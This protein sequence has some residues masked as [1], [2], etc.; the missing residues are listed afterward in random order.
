MAIYA[1]VV[2]LLISPVIILRKKPSTDGWV[3]SVLLLFPIFC[4]V[5]FWFLFSIFYRDSTLEDRALLLI[6]ALGI[7]VTYTAW[8]EMLWRSYHKQW[9]LSIKEGYAVG[10]IILLLACW[11]TFIFFLFLCGGIVKL[12][13]DQALLLI[14]ALVLFRRTGEFISNVISFLM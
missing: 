14:V 9:S 7:A 8:W 1:F 10:N 13:F 3:K 5:A 4:F 2:W 6:Y 11:P 12:L